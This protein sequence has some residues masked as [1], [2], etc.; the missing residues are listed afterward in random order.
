MALNAGSN[1]FC[2]AARRR[3]ATGVGLYFLS[4]VILCVTDGGF[5]VR[6]KDEQVVAQQPT[7][8]LQSCHASPHDDGSGR[9]LLLTFAG[10]IGDDKSH[11][12]RARFDL[13]LQNA[14]EAEL[15]KVRARWQHR[16]KMS[17]LRARPTR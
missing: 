5:S 9:R 12:A 17:P 6:I 15:L 1:L 4:D 8:S 13:E 3:Q 11:R 10:G 14:A 7:R 2:F 16:C